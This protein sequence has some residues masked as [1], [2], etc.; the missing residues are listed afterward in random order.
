MVFGLIDMPHVDHIN[1]AFVSVTMSHEMKARL[2]A[3]ADR[4]TRG[5]LAKLIRQVLA[6]KYNLSPNWKDEKNEK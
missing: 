6:K 2:K 4:E 3:I 1:K 5:D